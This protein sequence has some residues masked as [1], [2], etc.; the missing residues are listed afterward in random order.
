MAELSKAR[1]RGRSLVG[2]AV[3]NPAGS[4]VVSVVSVSVCVSCQVEVSATGRSLTQRSPTDCGVSLCMISK[5]QEGGGPGSRWAVASQEKNV[6][7][8]QTPNQR[9]KSTNNTT[10]YATL[11][12]NVNRHNDDI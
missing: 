7:Q 5:P 8:S 6:I 1:V 2:I 4:M 10:G 12:A 11:P 9:M 3:S